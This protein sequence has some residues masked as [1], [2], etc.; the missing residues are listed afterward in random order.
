MNICKNAL[1]KC[2][3]GCIANSKAWGQEGFRGIIKGIWGLI[4]KRKH[5]HIH[6]YKI[7][8]EKE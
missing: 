4:L 3:E 2:P 1:E 6:I 5:M 8:F 7:S